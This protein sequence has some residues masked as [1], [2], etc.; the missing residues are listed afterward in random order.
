MGSKDL[1]GRRACQGGCAQVT[2]PTHPTPTPVSLPHLAA[3][4]HEKLGTTASSTRRL[5]G[6]LAEIGPIDGG[7]SGGGGL[8]AVASH[9][10]RNKALAAVRR[11]AATVTT[12]GLRVVGSGG[13]GSGG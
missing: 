3:A 12:G 1:R 11:G 8:E 13:Q 5:P 10:E 9:I 7:Q 2:P 6:E 4:V